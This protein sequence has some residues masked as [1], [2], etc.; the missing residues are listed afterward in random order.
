MDISFVQVVGQL[1]WWI[2]LLVFYL[3]K[4]GMDTLRPQ[5][6]P[7]KKLII[8]PLIFMYLSV[9]S[10]LSQSSVAQIQIGVW[11]AGA[12][13]GLF[14]GIWLVSRLELVFDKVQYLVKIPGTWSTLA[15]IVLVFASKFYLGYTAAVDGGQSGQQE[16]L[17]LLA[18]A[19][20]GLGS[21]IITGRVVGYFQRFFASDSVTL[22]G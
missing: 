2:Y 11:A 13:L 1:P 8:T 15:V 12:L 7:L 19:G 17:K 4:K 5:I 21:G 6:V 3:V 20:A 22:P 14:G 9:H 10:L 16:L 18:L